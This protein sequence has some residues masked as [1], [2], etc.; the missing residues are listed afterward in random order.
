MRL[1]GAA[2]RVDEQVLAAHEARFDLLLELGRHADVLAEVEALVEAE[3][4]RERLRAQQMLALYRAHRQTDALAV[5]RATRILLVEGLGVEPARALRELEQAILRQ[6]PELDVVSASGS[7]PLSRTV[8]AGAPSEPGWIELPDGQAIAVVDTMV[9]GRS[10]DAAIRLV[11]SRVS[12]EHARVETDESGVRIV[13]LG[14][15]NGITVNGE[16]IETIALSDGDAVGLGG[17][18]VRYHTTTPGPT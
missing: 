8:R 15:T 10:P 1:D 7:L 18:I 4:Y 3:P 17:V 2:R 16:Q 11:D 13:D 5:F 12:R 14:S 9:I 6:D